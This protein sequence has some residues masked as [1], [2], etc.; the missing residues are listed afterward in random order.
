MVRWNKGRR[1]KEEDEMDEMDKMEIVRR[2]WQCK[3]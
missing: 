2:L 3:E 1:M